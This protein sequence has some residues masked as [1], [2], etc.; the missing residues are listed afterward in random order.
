MS[1]IRNMIRGSTAFLLSGMLLLSACPALVSADSGETLSAGQ[2]ATATQFMDCFEPMP[3]VESL[4]GDSWGNV[5]C[6]VAETF[7]FFEVYLKY[8]R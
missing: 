2:G 1:Q 8:R 4:S 6:P 3:I 7:H 5:A